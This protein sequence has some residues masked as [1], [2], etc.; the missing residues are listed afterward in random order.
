M[1]SLTAALSR[2]A[3]RVLLREHDFDFADNE[4]I[5]LRDSVILRTRFYGDHGPLI[6]TNRRPS[7]RARDSRLTGGKPKIDVPFRDIASVSARRRKRGL[8]HALSQDSIV[9]VLK[10]DTS[11][12]FE[13]GFAETWEKTIREQT[14]RSRN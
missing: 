10:N 6:L 12:E 1:A 2:L 5:L 11:Y 14:T 4:S 3:R 8:R 7:F 9:V 13:S